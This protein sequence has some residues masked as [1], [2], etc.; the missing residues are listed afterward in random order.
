MPPVKTS[1]DNIEK[2]VRRERAKATV[3]SGAKEGRP[4]P[5]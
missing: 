2:L 3:G 4:K 5:P 1:T